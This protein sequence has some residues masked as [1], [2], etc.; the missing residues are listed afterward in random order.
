MTVDLVVPAID[1]LLFLCSKYFK[2][3]QKNFAKRLD[4][5]LNGW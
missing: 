5:P 3:N 4:T 1:P 2:I